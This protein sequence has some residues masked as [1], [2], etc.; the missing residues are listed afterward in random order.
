M[1]TLQYHV[2]CLVRFAIKDEKDVKP[3]LKIIQK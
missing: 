3:N 1:P 2:N